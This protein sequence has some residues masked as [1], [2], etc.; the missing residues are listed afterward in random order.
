MED[1]REKTKQLLWT[2]LLKKLSALRGGGGRRG[3]LVFGGERLE[4]LGAFHGLPLFAPLACLLHLEA[5]RLRL[6]TGRE[7]RR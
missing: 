3:G 4:D 2:R 7:A 5:T 6:V 1:R